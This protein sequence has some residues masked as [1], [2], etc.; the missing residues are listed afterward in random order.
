MT[1]ILREEKFCIQTSCR[2]GEGWAPPG[3]SCPRHATW[4]STHDQTRLQ[5]R[6]KSPY[7]QSFD[8]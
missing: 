3:S 1:T 5:V 6:E 8:F 2:P 7:A 4:L